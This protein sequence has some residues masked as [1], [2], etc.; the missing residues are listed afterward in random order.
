M[1]NPEVIPEL[2]KGCWI[3]GEYV[4]TTPENYKLITLYRLYE[5]I[6]HYN[7]FEKG[8]DMA[9]LYVKYKIADYRGEDTTNIQE[10][11]DTAYQKTY[12]QYKDFNCF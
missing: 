9:D 8:N 4:L 3:E 2:K 1:N 11:I 5:H 12:N 10:E 6:F 7:Q